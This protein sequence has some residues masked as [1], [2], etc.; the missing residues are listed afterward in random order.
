MTYKQAFHDS[1]IASAT[2][3]CTWIDIF[4]ISGTR[5]I[6]LQK[7]TLPGVI[8]YAAFTPINF[9]NEQVPVHP[10]NE[11]IEVL[12]EYA[13]ITKDNTAILN[14]VFLSKEPVVYVKAHC[15]DWRPCPVENSS[16]KWA[17]IAAIVSMFI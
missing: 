11:L 4:G 10:S 13:S 12:R 7:S 1:L 14:D 5:L 3:K 6:S 17:K 15:A 16:S 9:I 2:I 8:G